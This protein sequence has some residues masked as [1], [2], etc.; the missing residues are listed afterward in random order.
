[1]EDL[2]A[3]FGGVDGAVLL[4]FAGVCEDGEDAADFGEDFRG[5]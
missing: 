4:A 1:M 3:C 5:G 2:D